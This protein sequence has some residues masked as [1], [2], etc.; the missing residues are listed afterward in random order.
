MCEGC[1]GHGRNCV[2]DF[3]TTF[4]SLNWSQCCLINLFMVQN[5]LCIFLD[6]ND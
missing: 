2:Y 4:I 3:S 5:Y 6:N 1:F